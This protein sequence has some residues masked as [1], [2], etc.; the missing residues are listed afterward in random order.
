MGPGDLLS[1][2]PDPS[3]GAVAAARADAGH[4]QVDAARIAGLGSG[5]RWS[6]YERGIRVI[7]AARWA[8]Y[9][10]ATGQHPMATV[11]RRSAAPLCPQIPT[12]PSPADSRAKPR[13]T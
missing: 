13:S 8:L 7:D 4:T 12:G 6:E 9:L 10:L 2:L 5:L 3:P 1:G 11:R